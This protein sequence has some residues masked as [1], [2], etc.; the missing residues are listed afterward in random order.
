MISPSAVLGI[1]AVAHT[2]LAVGVAVHGR[3]TDT[4]PGYWPLATLVVGVV[5]VAGYL[6]RRDRMGISTGR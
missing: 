5:G 4:D 1:T 6:W 3:R 2:L